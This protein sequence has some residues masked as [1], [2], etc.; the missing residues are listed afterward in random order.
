MKMSR[1][2]LVLVF[3]IDIM[4][5]IQYVFLMICAKKMFVIIPIHIDLFI[6]LLMLRIFA[7]EE[8][9]KL[10][11]LINKLRIVNRSTFLLVLRLLL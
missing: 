2:I 5:Y 7:I 4:E 3:V 9:T 6:H 10:D 1:N 11:E 8:K